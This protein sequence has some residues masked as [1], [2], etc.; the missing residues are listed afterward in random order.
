MGGFVAI[1][2]FYMEVEEEI[3]DQRAY[4][5]IPEIQK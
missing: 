4:N 3:R 5:S 1:A 2:T